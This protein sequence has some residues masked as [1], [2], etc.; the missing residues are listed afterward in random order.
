M[1]ADRRGITTKNK[2]KQRLNCI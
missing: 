1:A 2:R